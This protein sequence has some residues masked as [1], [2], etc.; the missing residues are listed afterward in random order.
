MGKDQQ[1]VLSLPPPNRETAHPSRTTMRIITTAIQP[2]AIRAEINALVPAIIALTAA[3]VAL[4]VAF[5]AS[6]V[7]FAVA[8]AVCAAFWAALADA[9]AVFCAAFA[10]CS[11][12]PIPLSVRKWK[13]TRR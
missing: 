9:F 12:V 6:A 1:D 3:M 4:T 10:V 8:F 2:P 5:V 13:P 11:V 7:A